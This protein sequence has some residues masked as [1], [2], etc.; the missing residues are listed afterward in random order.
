MYVPLTGML[1]GLLF[2]APQGYT[3]ALRDVIRLSPEISDLET[4]AGYIMC[5]PPRSGAATAAVPLNLSVRVVPELVRT[6][7]HPSGQAGP[8][9][10]TETSMISCSQYGNYGMILENDC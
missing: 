1:G 4:Q 5:E 10:T 6:A 9:R 3:E 2:V 8:N 7:T